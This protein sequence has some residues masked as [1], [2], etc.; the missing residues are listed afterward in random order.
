MHL[1]TLGLLFLA[2]AMLLP[3]SG[4][5]NSEELKA[6]SDYPRQV[7][8]QPRQIELD[9]WPDGKNVVLTVNTGCLTSSAHKLHNTLSLSVDDQA[10]ALIIDGHFVYT[11]LSKVV[12]RDCSKATSQRLSLQGVVPG[13]YRVL[14]NGK[15]LESVDLGNEVIFQS[16][17]KKR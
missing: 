8:L 12:K 14:L 1:K 6:Q 5:A 9:W 3:H 7:N 4:Q 2:A 16:S 13:N 15:A 10:N 11:L 17:I